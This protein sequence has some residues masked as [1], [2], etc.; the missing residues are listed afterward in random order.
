MR[1]YIRKFKCFVLGHKWGKATFSYYRHKET[2]EWVSDPAQH[3][4]RCGKFYVP[5]TEYP[6]YRNQGEGYIKY[7]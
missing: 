7:E 1:R 2:W 4:K 5:S 6:L 3:C